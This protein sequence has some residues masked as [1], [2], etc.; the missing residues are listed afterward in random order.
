MEEGREVGV[1]VKGG[2]VEF[3]FLLCVRLG[4]CNF[5]YIYLFFCYMIRLGRCSYSF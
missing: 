5:I 3:A 2:V 4:G 1:G